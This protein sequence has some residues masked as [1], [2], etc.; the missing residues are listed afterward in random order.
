MKPETL[1]ISISVFA[2]LA[3]ELALIADQIHMYKTLDCIEKSLRSM[4]RIEGL[5]YNRNTKEG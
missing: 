5:N 1:A 4:S 2:I 3:I